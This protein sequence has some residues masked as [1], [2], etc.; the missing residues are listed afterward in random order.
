MFRR[1]VTRDYHCRREAV[2]HWLFSTIERIVDGGH[3]IPIKNREL[4]PGE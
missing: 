4:E 1:I 2:Y 3:D